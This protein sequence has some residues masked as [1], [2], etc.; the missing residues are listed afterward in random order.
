MENVQNKFE[1]QSRNLA[2]ELAAKFVHEDVKLYA[3]D[4]NMDE[5]GV[6]TFFNYAGDWLQGYEDE[7]ASVE[8][9][10]ADGMGAPIKFFWYMMVS[11]ESTVDSAKQS[12]CFLP[13]VVEAILKLDSIVTTR[14]NLDMG[15]SYDT[16]SAV[17]SSAVAEVVSFIKKHRVVPEQGIKLDFDELAGIHESLSEAGLAIQYDAFNGGWQ[18]LDID[19]VNLV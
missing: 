19:P 5:E 9:Q 6:K 8:Q 14:V 1:E 13:D 10:L 11:A 2:A 17:D 4:S 16:S 3:Y 15:L 12:W 18:V 7:V